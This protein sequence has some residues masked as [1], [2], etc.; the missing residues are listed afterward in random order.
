MI[1][2]S[3]KARLARIVLFI[4]GLMSGGHALA[5]I[6]G[7]PPEAIP[8]AA[9]KGLV[10]AVRRDMVEPL[11]L[12]T[13]YYCTDKN[14][15]RAT[16][17]TVLVPQDDGSESGSTLTCST[18]KDRPRDWICQVD[19]YDVI[20]WR[21]A[22]VSR[23]CRWRLATGFRS[24]SREL[25]QRRLSRFWARPVRSRPAQVTCAGCSPPS[26]CA[27]TWLGV[28]DPTEWSIPARLCAAAGSHPHPFQIRHPGHGGGAHRVLGRGKR[29][30]MTRG[31]HGDFDVRT[32]A[33]IL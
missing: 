18:D 19:H 24:R 17:D 31:D 15:A 30:R 27:P 3:S 29:R 1:V 12:A 10:K 2:T 6:A 25:V 23:R 26:L 22:R 13:L 7:C 16:V 20:P 8:A 14:L 33:S 9:Q 28:T 32:G 21:R 5:D 4:V 11:N